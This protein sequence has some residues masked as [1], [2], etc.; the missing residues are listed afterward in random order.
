MAIFLTE[1]ANWL[2]AAGLTVIEYQGWKT[3]A[4]GSGGYAAM[5]LCV[6]WHQT[7]SGSSWDGQRDADYCA[8]GDPNSPVSNLYIDRK[9]Q[10]W[11]L[12]AGA[13]NTNG[14]GNS[15]RFSRGTVPQDGMNTRAVGVEMG[16][17][18]VGE[19][20]PQC[21]VDAMFLTSNTINARIG[22][23]PTD[24]AGHWDYAPTRKIDPAT[25]AAVQGPWRPRSVTSSGTWSIDDIRSE[26][27][28]RASGA[29]PSPT[30]PP[31]PTPEPSPDDWYV[32]VMQNMQV[33]RQGDQGFYVLVMQ[34]LM[35]AVGA[36]NEANTANYDG[37][38]GSGTAGALNRYKQAL[39]LPADGVCDVQVWTALMDASN[40][41]PSI[42][43][44]DS[45]IYVKRMQHLLSA[46]GQMN[47]A[48]LNNFDSVWGNGT[49][50]AKSRFD[51]T[52]NLYDP[53][54]TS[55]G[56]KSWESLLMGYVW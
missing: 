51:Q 32:W 19:P 10:V 11:V 37:V 30:P 49:D 14:K 23:Q 20:W 46:A 47:N 17:N 21:Q 48:N 36:M 9:G 18:G 39:G 45:N 44:G 52:V 33:V 35:C 12:A 50:G 13:T 40:G 7:A 22:N 27:V 6:M 5:P 26:C 1:M 31:T 43:R 41:I 55:C 38:F 34:H 8:V 53:N 24:C 25:A 54:D 56:P 15:M 28:R 16:N 42:K 3:R 29:G 4:R 2:R